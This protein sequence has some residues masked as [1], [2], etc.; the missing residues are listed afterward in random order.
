MNKIEKLYN[1]T[2]YKTFDF[3]YKLI[4]FNLLFILTTIFGLVVF[5]YMTSLIILV[6]AIKSLTDNQDFSIVKTWILNIKKHYKKALKISIFYT[7]IALLFTYNTMF[8]YIAV[9]E[10]GSTI[11]SVLFSTMLI[12]DFGFLFGMI[13]A[14]FVYVYFPNL[15]VKKTIYHSFQ[16]IRI[17]PAQAIILVIMSII[18]LALIYV[19][20]LF[21]I[22]IGFSLVILVFYKLVDPTYK[23]LVE[24]NTKSLDIR[25]I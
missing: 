9:T 18:L 23:R 13:N 6:L 4:M 3:I 25:D 16:L 15:S 11:Y 21:V 19:V 24:K 20:P 2:F 12:I 22:F 7:V 10:D 5:G 1:S 14:A 8:F 17:V